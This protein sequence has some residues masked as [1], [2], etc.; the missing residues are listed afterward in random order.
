MKYV[1][2]SYT[3]N[4]T[5]AVLAYDDNGSMYGVVTVN[6]FGSERLPENCQFVDENNWDGIVEKL[7]KEGI[8]EKLMDRFRDPVMGHSGFCIYTA[9]KFNID[10][11]VEAK[12][13]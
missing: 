3:N 8:A 13:G 1:K 9:M 5:L 6:L 4:G 12:N 11:L 7:E 2:S 10:K